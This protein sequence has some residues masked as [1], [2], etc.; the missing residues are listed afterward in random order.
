MQGAEANIVEVATLDELAQRIN[1][2]HAAFERSGTLIERA[3]EAGKLLLE[4]KGQLDSR[5][6]SP[7]LRDNFHGSRATA[8]RYIMVAQNEERLCVSRVRQITLRSAVKLLTK[9]AHT[10]GET[11]SEPT[12]A[13]EP[14]DEIRTA[15]LQDFIRAGRRFACIYADPAWPYD[16]QTTR[17]ST[18]DH[19]ATM[20]LEDICGM[21]IQDIAADAA[22][23]HLWTTTAFLFDARTVME[24]WG[25][26]FK[27]CLIWVKS[28]MGMGNY[29]RQSHEYLLLGVRGDATRFRV[30]DEMSW[31]EA[32]RRKHS[33]KPEIFREKI[34][35]VSHGPYVELFSRQAVPGWSAW[36]NEIAPAERKLFT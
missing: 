29:W 36:G 25:F 34:E 11:L 7:W 21:P 9:D 35:R 22:H 31:V 19:Y 20:S 30:R 6:F 3:I 15:D 12:P 27:S 23:L 28:Q 1:A 2:A 24:A 17:G 18:D 32:P 10:A 14:A 4:A 8:Y 33:A 26:E 13:P 16:N 5:S